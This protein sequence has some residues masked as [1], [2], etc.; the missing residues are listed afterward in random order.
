[1]RVV[2]VFIFVSSFMHAVDLQK[3]ANQARL[4]YKNGDYESTLLL[5]KTILK[6]IPNHVGMLCNTGF[7]LKQ[8][9]NFNDAF[10]YY[11]KA[12]ELEPTNSRA[13]RGISHLYLMN[14]DFKNGWP[15][16]EYRWV[17]PPAYNQELQKYIQ[18]GNNLQNKTVLLKTEYGLGDTLQFIRYAQQLKQNGAT[19]IVESQNPLVKLLQLCPYIDQVVPEKTSVHS[20]FTALLMSMPLIYDTTLQTIPNTVPYLYADKNLVKYWAT[21]I[22]TNYY[23]IGICW[24]A[25]THTNSDITQVKKDSNNKS[26]ALKLLAQLSVLPNVRLYS[27]QKIHGLEQLQTLPAHY[28]IT[29]FYELDTKYGPFMDTAALIKNLDL[30]VTIDTSIAHLAG[31]LGTQTFVLLPYHADWRWLQDRTYSPWYPN[32]TLFRQ[33]KTGDWDSVVASVAQYITNMFP[34]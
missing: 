5:Y 26:I 18:S 34:D 24:Q 25:E 15:A 19:V 3:I 4:T 33:K 13:Q 7:I 8:L 1:M 21:K 9:G 11:Q 10:P 28:P 6:H 23:N 22:D 16:Y 27:L 14:G 30:V 2:I 12:R 17:N 31:G 29:V 20:D 32:I